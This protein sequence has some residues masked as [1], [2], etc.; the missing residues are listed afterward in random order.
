LHPVSILF[1]HIIDDARSKPHQTS[2][3]SNTDLFMSIPEE[4]YM[5]LMLIRMTKNRKLNRPLRKGTRMCTAGCN[6]KQKNSCN[7]FTV[8]QSKMPIL[9]FTLHEVALMLVSFD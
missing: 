7:K 9:H 6:H 4:N 8:H 5:G 3:K 2:L 1:P